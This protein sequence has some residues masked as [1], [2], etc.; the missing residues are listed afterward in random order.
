MDAENAF[1][2]INR[3]IQDRSDQ[4][5]NKC[6]TQ[7]LKD[8]LEVNDAEIIAE[9][10]HPFLNSIRPDVLMRHDQSKTICIEMFY[11]INKTP[12]TLAT[13]VLKKMDRYMK[14]LDFYNLQPRLVFEDS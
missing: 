3:Y 4:P 12:S 13:Y 7:G 10:A 14:Q 6:L 1:M 2:E 11:T 5:I 8:C 9:Q